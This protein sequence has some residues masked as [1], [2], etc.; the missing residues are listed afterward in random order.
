MLAVA[1]ENV[2]DVGGCAVVCVAC[3]ADGDSDRQ[4]PSN[5]MIASVLAV[6]IEN[7]NRT[8]PPLVEGENG[9]QFD[10]VQCQI[11][12][13]PCHSI[14]A[15]DVVTVIFA[16]EQALFAGIKLFL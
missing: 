10:F 13:I 1:S 15:V 3:F 12:H 11:P 4:P 7:P 9:L 16:F 6:I 8:G 14:D 5:E 2:P